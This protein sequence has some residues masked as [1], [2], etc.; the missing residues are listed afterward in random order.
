MKQGSKA[1]R[2]KGSKEDNN[3]TKKLGSCDINRKQ[4]SNTAI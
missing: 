1:Q 3:E 4:F 2:L